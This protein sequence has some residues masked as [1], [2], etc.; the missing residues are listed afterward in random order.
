L[1]Q[2]SRIHYRRHGEAAGGRYVLYWMQRAQRANFNHA[3][4]HAVD[5]ANRLALPVVVGFGLMDDYPEANERHYAFMLEGLSEVAQSLRERGIAFVL[6]HGHPAATMSALAEDAALLVCDRGYLRHEKAWRESVAAAVRCPVVEIETDVV[7]PVESASAKAESAARTLRPKIG[8]LLDEYL[9]PLE[10]AVP[11]HPSP[12]LCLASDLDIRDVDGTLR[13]L[14]L[15]RSVGRVCAFRGG[16]AEAKRRLDAFIAEHL[17]G[18]VENRGEPA[19][20]A[21]SMMSPYLHFGQISPLDIALRIRALGVGDAH[22]YLEE[23]IVRRELAVNFVNFTPAYDSF[24]SLPSWA[25]KTLAAHARDERPV[26]H[27]AATLEAMATGDVYWNAATKEMVTT[28]YMHNHMRMYWGKKIL[29][30]SARPED[31]YAT[32]L[33]LNNKYLLDGRDANS[34]AGIGWVFG[35]HDRPWFDRPIFGTVRY[36]NARGLERKFDIA[37][38]VAKVARL[39]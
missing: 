16:A 38:Y 21:T 6:R 9:H 7:V 2:A 12:E 11:R 36:M 29:E 37:A 4:E 19:A 14:R 35:L 13:R 1:I 30:W 27:D 34:F 10:P 22:V 15:D 20:G 32:A 8:R 33:A 26:R 3:L 23:L 24:A 25:R 17:V 5:R 31:G 39:S 18:Y 28:G